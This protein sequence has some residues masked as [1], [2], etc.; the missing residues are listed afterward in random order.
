MRNVPRA[1]EVRYFRCVEGRLPL[2][3]VDSDTHGRKPGPCQSSGLHDQ[4][5]VIIDLRRFFQSR[6]VTHASEREPSAVAEW[7]KRFLLTPESLAV[8]TGY[9]M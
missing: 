1:E 5:N 2:D 4:K 6:G 7:L 3:P 8:N 9:C